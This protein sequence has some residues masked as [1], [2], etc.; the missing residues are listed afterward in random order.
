ML[1]Q[2][3]KMKIA[4]YGT[5]K[6]GRIV[7]DFAEKWGA[8]IQYFVNSNPECRI[9]NG[10]N[11]IAPEDIVWDEI[12]YIVIASVLHQDEILDRLDSLIISDNRSKILKEFEFMDKLKVMKSD[13]QVCTVDGDISYLATKEDEIIAKFMHYS[14]RNWSDNMIKFFLDYVCNE[15]VDEPIFF[16]IGANIGTTSIFAKK[17]KNNLKVI[18]FEPCRTNNKLFKVNAILNDVDDIII[19]KYAVTNKT[20]KMTF[21]Y[22]LENPGA[23]CVCLT[24]NK[25]L[26]E[27]YGISLDEYI[28]LHKINVQDIGYIWIDVEGF[29]S[30]V[31]IGAKQTI[32]KSKAPILLEY[33]PNDYKDRGEYDEML[34]I[35]EQNYNFFVDMSTLDTKVKK[36]KTTILRDYSCMLTRTT[37][38]MFFN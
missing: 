31:I 17:Y 5:G 1:T 7:Q 16:D 4:V 34:A 13:Y 15:T 9:F 2:K 36:E 35:I 6:H 21:S 27:V 19:E 25:D 3:E 8:K 30:A 18:G 10:Y 37:D 20:Q 14:G 12:D 26:E 24:E 29:E 33:S 32:F 28:N 38:M 22:N 11:V 23:S